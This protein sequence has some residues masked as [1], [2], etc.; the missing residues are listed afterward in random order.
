MT[1]IIVARLY[2]Y[3]YTSQLNC[4]KSNL[5]CCVGADGTGFAFEEHGGVGASLVM[6][7]VVALRRGN[8]KPLSPRGAEVVYDIYIYIYSFENPLDDIIILSL[9]YIYNACQ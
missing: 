4:L 1:M 2:I 3:M 8:F 6:A 7:V 5:S 9:I